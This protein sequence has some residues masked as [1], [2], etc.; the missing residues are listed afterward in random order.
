MKAVLFDLDYT[1]YDTD[2]YV[3]G[4]FGDVAR[5]LVDKYSLPQTEIY[6]YLGQLWNEKTSAY[7]Y[8][9]DDL[10]EHFSLKEENVNTIVEIFNKHKIVSVQLFADTIPTLKRLRLKNFKLGIITDGDA[11]RQR[12][13]IQE[14][15][16]D[17]LIDNIVYAKNLEPKPSSLPFTAALKELDVKPS[18]AIYVADNP[19][20]DF[21]GAKMI[22]IKTVRILRGKFSEITINDYVDHTIENLDEILEILDSK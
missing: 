20:V 4:A 7:P 19:S 15:G 1:L 22:G 8:L 16:L 18:S 2:K 17:K 10:L 12:R 5:Y 6:Q 21:K 13:K 3:M 9:F 14:S 11:M